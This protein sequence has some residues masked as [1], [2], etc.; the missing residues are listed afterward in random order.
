MD[1]G[2]VGAGGAGAEGPESPGASL[3]WQRAQDALADL[4][5]A[6][7]ALSKGMDGREHVAATA[8]DSVEAL[9]SELA[10]A[11]RIGDGMQSSL[12]AKER[13]LLL[14][15]EEIRLLRGERGRLESRA[16]AQGTRIAELERLADSLFEDVELLLQSRRWR[17]GHA[18]LSLPARLLGRGRPKT[19]ADHIAEL[20]RGYRPTTED[21]LTL[22]SSGGERPDRLHGATSTARIPRK[23]KQTTVLVLSWDVGHNPLGRA[24]MLAEALQRSYTVVLAGFQ[25]PRY[26][27]AVWKPLRDAPFETVT[28]AGRSFPDYQR[29]VEGLARRDRCRR[30]GGLQGE[31]AGGAVGIDGQGLAKSPLAH[32]RG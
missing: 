28:I 10:A 19:V 3:A 32:R 4:R 25:F 12:A 1:D 24:Y 9:E 31:A 22:A 5:D 15:L 30:G 13:D 7:V 2:Q 23:R 21:S 17:F 8:A 27:R 26:G 14:A 6:Y 11:E 20:R 29:T 16:R 18:L